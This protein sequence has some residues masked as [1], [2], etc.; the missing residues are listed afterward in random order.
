MA[1]ADPRGDQDPAGEPLEEA[2]AMAADVDEVVAVGVNCCTPADVAPAV[3]LAATHAG[4]PTLAEP[5]SGESWD[6]V[7]RGWLE[8]PDGIGTRDGHRLDHLV[9]TGAD[10]VGGCCR[11]TPADVA[12]LSA[13][14][15][16][17]PGT[18]A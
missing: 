8:D 14:L 9:D 5:N 10:L 1:V 7:G 15:A 6:A 17:A 16:E 4:K 2:F 12:A 18:A 13:L 3:E 11:T